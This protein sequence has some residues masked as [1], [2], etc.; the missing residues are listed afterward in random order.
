VTKDL[1]RDKDAIETKAADENQEDPLKDDAADDL[2]A[3]LA[4]LSVDRKCTICGRALDASN[5]TPK[6]TACTDCSAQLERQKAR[7][8]EYEDHPDLPPTSAKVRKIVDL[9]SETK[10]AG[11]GEKT[12]IFSQFTSFLDILEPFLDV[13][14]IRFVRRKC[15]A[16]DTASKSLMWM[17]YRSGRVHEA[18]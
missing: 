18:R 17:E 3:A 9:L 11:E 2:A 5:A 10:K 13:E 4:G 7:A 16:Y 15:L 6:D 1:T 12:I 14:G 8:T